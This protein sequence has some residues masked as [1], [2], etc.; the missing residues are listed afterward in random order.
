MIRLLSLLSLVILSLATVAARAQDPVTLV[1]YT[2]ESYGL[3]AVVPEGWTD[4]GGGIFARQASPSDETLLVQQAAPL[5]AEALLATILLQLGIT[6]SLDPSGEHQGAALAWTLYE[7]ETLG[8][9]VDFALATEDDTTY[10]VMLQSS[11]GERDDLRDEVYIPALDALAPYAASDEPV[12]YDVAEV[13]FENGPV[14]LAGTLTLPS[15][16]GPHPALVLVSGSAPRIATKRWPASR[17][18]PSS[19]WPTR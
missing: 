1:P 15:T 14:T 19:C 10:V 4:L 11:P 13:T 9:A 16:A 5:T 6:E 18:D 12:P 8:V 2:S 3:T 7:V 17:S